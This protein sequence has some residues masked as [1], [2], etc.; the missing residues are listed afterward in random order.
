MGRGQKRNFRPFKNI[1]PFLPVDWNLEILNVSLED[2]GL[3]ECQIL[4]SRS[5][6]A[7]LTVL[8]PPRPPYVEGGPVREVIEDEQVRLQCVSVGGKPAPK[9]S[10][11]WMDGWMDFFLGGGE[12]RGNRLLS[13][14]VRC[15]IIP[16]WRFPTSIFPK[17]KY[18]SFQLCCIPFL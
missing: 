2:D 14:R 15:I 8:V 16:S 18:F 9:V 7:R 6:P 12:R 5:P 11:D 4:G 1:G 13:Q 10:T 3:Y 17:K